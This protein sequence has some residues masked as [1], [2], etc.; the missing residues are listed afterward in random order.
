MPQE[1]WGHSIWF[2]TSSQSVSILR[3]A[4]TAQILLLEFSKDGSGKIYMWWFS[5]QASDTVVVTLLLLQ[6]VSVLFPVS[7]QLLRLHEIC[8]FLLDVAVDAFLNDV[9]KKLPS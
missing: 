3:S 4:R 8:D 9:Q 5:Q 7:M 1:H 6:G 2:S